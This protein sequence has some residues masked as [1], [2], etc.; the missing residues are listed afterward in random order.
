MFV[1][2][3]PLASFC[4]TCNGLVISVP[5]TRPS[6]ISGTARSGGD[7]S[8]NRPSAL[9]PSPWEIPPAPPGLGSVKAVVSAPFVRAVGIIFPHIAAVGSVLLEHHLRHPV[10]AY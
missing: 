7:F 1:I 2:S 10:H 8:A 3:A 4:P 9:F 6:S 5:A